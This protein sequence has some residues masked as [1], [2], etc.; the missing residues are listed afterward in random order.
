MST[1]TRVPAGTPAAAALTL[2]GADPDVLYAVG[3]DLQT[4]IG[5][6]IGERNAMAGQRVVQYSSTCG[7]MAKCFFSRDNAFLD[8][9]AHLTAMSPDKFAP[10]ATQLVADG[11]PNDGTGDLQ[12][13]LLLLSP[14]EHHGD[15]ERCGHACSFPRR[16]WRCRH[17]AARGRRPRGRWRR[18]DRLYAAEPGTRFL[19]SSSW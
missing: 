13:Q 4:S 12:L 19:C 15:S 14:V 8:L 6:V 16:N 3:T 10:A 2:R 17:Y 9:P 18:S 11:M 1:F 5:Y 7:A